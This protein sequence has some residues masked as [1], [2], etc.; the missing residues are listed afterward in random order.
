MS[1]ELLPE[2]DH[3]DVLYI[4]GERDD[5]PFFESAGII[6]RGPEQ[7]LLAARRHK[8][9]ED[10]LEPRQVVAITRYQAAALHQQERLHGWV[11]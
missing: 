11:P 9:G 7:S 4:P 5:P 2:R 1:D 10:D 3:Y 8:R 6:N